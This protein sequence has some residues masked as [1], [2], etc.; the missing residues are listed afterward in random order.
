MPLKV[1]INTIYIFKVTQKVW[2]KAKTPYHFYVFYNLYS[3][4]KH[5]LYIPLGYML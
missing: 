1:K 4:S 2:K 5:V 3:S